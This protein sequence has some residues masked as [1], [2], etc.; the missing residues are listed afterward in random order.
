MLDALLGVA[1][2]AG[3]RVTLIGLLPT[4]I[5]ALWILFLVW[6]GAPSDAPSVDRFVDHL[7]D[8]STTEVLLG[9][10][11]LLGFAILSQPLQLPLVRL[12]EGYWPAAA[13]GLA[14]RRRTAH[15]A[16]RAKLEAAQMTSGDADGAEPGGAAERA[17]RDRAAWRLR[18][19]YPPDPLVMPTALGNALRTA[20]DRAGRRYGLDT[21]AVWPRLYPVLGER[22]LA[23]VDD[24]RTQL[25]VAVR[26]CVV[27]LVAAVV[28]L[29]LLAT[30]GWLLLVPAATFALAWLAYKGSVGAAVAYGEGLETAFDL[31]RFDLLR[32]LHLP[33]PADSEQER[34]QNAQVTA[35]FFMG[36]RAG[37][38]YAHGDA[39]APAGED[40]PAPVED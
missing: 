40:A 15:R 22:V 2:D 30:Q 37:F 32:A 31:H 12:L 16:R 18:K 13:D 6:G 33:L 26:F 27:L 8:L 23:I 9:F 1:K 17:A 34:A 35:F 14:E 39:G 20:E 19:L 3:R 36:T 25:D 10:L 38:A 4:A 29:G 28:S 21:V 11:A 5:L 24:E 7:E